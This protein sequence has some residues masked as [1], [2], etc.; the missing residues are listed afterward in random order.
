MRA[1]ATMFD[2][3]RGHGPLLQVGIEK[4]SIPFIQ[5]SISRIAGSTAVLFM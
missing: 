4:G 5:R 1:I 2:S 3:F